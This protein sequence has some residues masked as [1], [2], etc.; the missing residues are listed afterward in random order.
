MEKR[1]YREALSSD[2]AIK[3]IQADVDKKW[4]AKL[5]DEF[6]SLVKTDFE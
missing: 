4:S 1:P 3:T 2:D 6:I 5:A